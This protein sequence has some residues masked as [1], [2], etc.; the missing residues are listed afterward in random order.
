MHRFLPLL[1]RNIVAFI[2][3]TPLIGTAESS[4]EKRRPNILVIMTD[5]M[6]FSDLGC[7]GSEISTPHLDALAK[8]GVRFTQFYNTARCCPTRA[9]LLTGLY[10]HQAGIGHMM[11]DRG[12]EGYR[13]DLNRQSVTIAEVLRPA[14]YR[15]YSIGKWH[16]TKSSNAKTDAE[17][18]NWPLQRGFDRFYGTIAGAGNFWDPNHL[19][20]DNQAISPFA[21][22]EYQPVDTYYYTDAI[23]D[24]AVKFLKDHDQDHKEQPF[25]MYVAFTAAHW[26][27]QARE[28]DI[29]K[30]K[31]RYAQGYQAI[32]DARYK[33]ML[34]SG[35]V[36]KADSTLTPIKGG[37]EGTPD[38]EWEQRNMEV[39]AA[40]I[41]SMDQGVGRIVAELKAQGKLEDTLICYLQDNG[42]CAEELGNGVEG[43]P[44]ANQPSLS[45]I[46]L[47]AIRGDYPPK[48]TRDGYPVRSGKGVMAGPTDTW[49]AY[50]ETWASVSNTPF[51]EFKHWVHEGGIATPLIVHWPQGM[52]VKKKG[53]LNPE[54][55]HLIDIMATCVDVAGAEYP[56]EKEGHQIKAYQG[57][58]FASLLRE[59]EKDQPTRALFW[60]H[61]GNRAVRENQWKLVAKENQPWELYDMIK[62]RSELHDLSKEQPQKVKDLE[63]KWNEYAA[64]SDVLPLGAWRA[65]RRIRSQKTEFHLKKG[66][67]LEGSEA[68]DIEG[69]ELHLEVTFELKE[70][71]SGVLVAQGGSQHGYSLYLEKFQIVFTVRRG[72]KLERLHLSIRA[73]AHVVRAYLDSD[74][75]IHLMLEGQKVSSSGT[76]HFLVQPGDGLQVGDDKGGKVSDYKGS[77]NFSGKISSV[78]LKLGKQ[79][80]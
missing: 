6:G 70:Q 13:G 16:V 29:A 42:A 21:D 66:E 11:N 80:K 41:D 61:E 79:A 17:K 14:G 31:Q 65:N 73:G 43:V 55:G 57:R 54:P 26:P 36:T 52:D 8:N 32:R 33:K 46:P 76:G 28:R 58:S 1:L 45:V 40:M 71:S 59:V 63:A 7:M 74:G 60:E 5:D 9:S 78:R 35:V 64:K 15:N 34:E 10:P 18:F 47:E 27:M 75:K 72:G 56:K 38:W 4:S 77:T 49:V 53:S 67:V 51:R 44:K 12:Y 39:Y 68:P 37:F 3:I 20:R 24:N 62:D 2:A 30:Y 25:F 22:Q 69:R 48:Q 19:V 50:G 23:A